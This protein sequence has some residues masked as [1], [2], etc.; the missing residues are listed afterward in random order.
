GV[1]Q[2]NEQPVKRERLSDFIDKEALGEKRLKIYREI[3]PNGARYE[4]GDE[5]DDSFYDNTPLYIVP[6]N[7][8]F[9][10]GDNRDYSTDSRFSSLGSI[11]AVN[12]IGP[13]YRRLVP[14]DRPLN[15]ALPD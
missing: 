14:R 5:K 9:V 11:P 1:L 8:Y 7:H 6:P 2:I 10:L 15:L 4:T 3:L 13:V 12:L